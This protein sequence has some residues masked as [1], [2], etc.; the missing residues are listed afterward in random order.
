MSADDLRDLLLRWQAGWVTARSY[1]SAMDGD[2]VTVD[3]GLAERRTET[4]LLDADPE[5]YAAV[6]ESVAG[7][8]QWLTAPTTDRA[9]THAAAVDAGFTP[10][11]PEWLM[12]RPLAGHP[13]PEVPAGYDTWLSG[14]PPLL[15]AE[16][17]TDGDGPRALAAKGHLAL[18]A[19]DAVADRIFTVP[20]HRRRGLGSIVMATLTT[21]ARERGAVTGLL[22]ASEQGRLLYERLGWRVVTELTVADWSGHGSPASPA[23]PLE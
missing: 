7:P 21:A 14:R 18:S 22:V 23:D 12:T 9:R 16:V 15:V 20:E 4:L 5:L 19:A 11:A 3:V 17:V 8:A 2:T 6:A 1:R 13:E 10:H